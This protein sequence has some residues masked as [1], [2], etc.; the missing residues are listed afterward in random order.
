MP[1]LAMND[2]VRH[3]SPSDSVSKRTLPEA[4][5]S[6]LIHDF[7]DSAYNGVLR[8]VG[9]KL[10]DQAARRVSTILRQ[11]AWEFSDFLARSLR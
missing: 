7:V 6:I 11:P 5:P 10:I 4:L 2:P 9:K 1:F 8:L 3:N